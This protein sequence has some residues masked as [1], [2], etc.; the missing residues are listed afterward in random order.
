MYQHASELD[1]LSAQERHTFVENNPEPIDA[2]K[3][4]VILGKLGSSCCV[5]GE[6]DVVVKEL[7]IV[8]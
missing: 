8:I 1:W 2:V 5:C 3:C 4:T 6:N 7:G